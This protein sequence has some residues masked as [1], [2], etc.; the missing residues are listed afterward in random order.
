LP[1]FGA[2]FLD[3]DFLDFSTLTFSTFG[4][5]TDAARADRIRGIKEKIARMGVTYRPGNASR[6]GHLY[7]PLPFK[8][9]E[10]IPFQREAVDERFE[11]I[12]SHLPPATQ[13]SR[14]LD[15]GCHAG[16][17]CFR[18]EDLGFTCTGIELDALTVEI[19]REVNTLYSRGVEFMC[20]EATPELIARLGRFDVCL[21]FATFQWI[22]KARGIPYAMEVTR[23]IMR[24][25]PVMFFETSMGMEGKAK[26]PELPNI[27]SVERMLSD[28]GVHRDI[29]CLGEI[30][31]PL[32]F[33]SRYVFVTRA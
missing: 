11:L 12:R 18:L 2:H 26:L 10:D 30:P 21:F 6:P 23:A 19:A 4:M 20:A 17:N 14:V 28:L 16:Y 27:D 9:F 22:A 15:V 29:R 1:R 24:C 13:G 8:D 31:A 32:T 5:T 25:A 33:Q 7:S 3:F